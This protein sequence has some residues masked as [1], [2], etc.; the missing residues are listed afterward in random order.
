MF[1]PL[2]SVKPASHQA[3]QVVPTFVPVQ[4]CSTPGP[5]G[6]PVVQ[7][8]G[9][10]RTEEAPQL[11][12]APQNRLSRVKFPT[13]L[14]PVA[15]NTA[16]SDAKSLLLDDTA[17]AAERGRN[18]PHPTRTHVIAM[19]SHSPL[20]HFATCVVGPTGAQNP[21]AHA[22]ARVLP[23]KRPSPDTVID[24]GAEN[25]SQM[26]SSHPNVRVVQ[27]PLSHISI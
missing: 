9:E 12:V 14:Y 26:V 5:S 21:C 25:S 17:Y 15:Q 11:D 27:I 10:H 18:S 22:R 8:S 13:G 19:F 16:A 3:T 6:I 20:S 23:C 7:R 4:L 2:K 24:S 1:S